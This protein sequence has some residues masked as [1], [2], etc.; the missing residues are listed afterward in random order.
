[1]ER[2]QFNI[3]WAVGVFGALFLLV[4][5]AVP[6]L[7]KIPSNPGAISGVGTILVYVFTQRDK[8]VKHNKEEEK[9]DEEREKASDQ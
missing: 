9:K 1:M 7:E 8:F 2:W 3:T 6:A 4:A 5:P